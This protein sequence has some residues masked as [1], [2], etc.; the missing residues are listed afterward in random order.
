METKFNLK[1][2]Y[3]STDGW[4]GYQQPVNAV[5][6]ANNTGEFSDSPCP[7]HIC[8]AE[9]TRAAKLLEGAKIP[10]RTMECETSN[11]FCTHVYIIVQGRMKK[12]AIK[13]IE[14]IVAEC[15]LLYIA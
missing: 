4:R 6:G 15:R 7:S 10:Y 9:I 14:P 13:L 1:L 11:V 8:A 3:V 2:K 12:R 5:C